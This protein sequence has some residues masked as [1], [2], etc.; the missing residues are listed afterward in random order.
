MFMAAGLKPPG[1][2][3][4]QS[5]QGGYF[6]GYISHTANGVA[7]HALIIAPRAT[8]A[9]G[10]LYPVT[11]GL[12]WK[13]SRT[14]TAGANN[15]YDGKVNTDA[16]VAAGITSHPAG[17]FCVNL[18]IGGYSDWYLP[19]WY[20]L[21]I[22]YYNLKP[23]TRSNQT[24]AGETAVPN[25]YAVPIRT[26]QYTSSVPQRTLATA[27]RTGGTQAMA[28]QFHWTSSQPA[29]S[30]VLAYIIATDNGNSSSNVFKDE[31]LYMTRAFRKISI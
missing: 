6:A 30:S 19:S 16:M 11:T 27:F 29:S 22:A 7:T 15:L 8:G 20:E 28:E 3:L 2:Q 21:E 31:V 13:T 4:G 25:N 17:Q 24:V 18:S 26:S 9:S 23:T 14:S 12:S 10:S 1:Y 5:L